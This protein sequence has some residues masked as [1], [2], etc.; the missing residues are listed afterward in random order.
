[1]PDSVPQSAWLRTTIRA[2]HLESTERVERRRRKYEQADPASPGISLPGRTPLDLPSELVAWT[3]RPDE[4]VLAVG[5][6]GEM[7]ALPDAPGGRITCLLPVRNAAD[8]LPGYLE[9]A[10]RFADRVIALDDG[11][12]DE[13]PHLLEASPLVAHVLRSPTRPGYAGWDDAANRQRLLD[14]AIEDDA[15]WVLFLDADERIDADDATALRG[16]VERAA[17][18]GHAYGFRVYRMVTDLV[19]YDRAELWVYRLFRARPGQVLPA[20]RLHLVPVPVGIERDR[21]RKTTVRIQHLS[22]LTPQRRTSRL[23]KYEQADPDRRWQR[24][25]RSLLDVG[26]SLRPWQQRPA[27]LPLLADPLG[28]GPAGE[29]DLA[30]LDPGAPLL[31][32][33]VISRNDAERIERS[34]SSVVSQECDVPFE[35]IVAAGGSD[36]T[37]ELVRRRFP[38]VTVVDV[39][40]PG[41]PGAARNAGLAV[42]RGE[43]VSFPGSH[44]E[45]P[46]GSLAARVRAH[47]LG[48]AMVTGSVL[49][50]TDTGPGWA[51]YFLDHSGSLPE[52]PSGELDAAPAHCSYTLEALLE[53]GGFPEDMRAGEDTVVNRELWTRGH[54]AYRARD[55]VLSHRNRCHTRARLVRHHFTR[56]RALGR[57]ILEGGRSRAG[58]LSYLRTYPRWR[59]GRTD[60]MVAEWGGELRTCYAA[61]R[62]LVRLGIVAACLGAAA[63]A[64][65]GRRSE[66]RRS[67]RT[68]TPAPAVADHHAGRLRAAGDAY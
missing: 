7:A 31:S 54:R 44:V 18:P 65:T 58:V 4:P 17:D 21:W 68:Q 47:E 39:P 10:V 38:S 50:G 40:E 60:S 57:I 34:V 20:Q 6:E 1:M 55:V 27:G 66:P 9:S 56:G 8:D 35:V 49:N 48:Y 11:S 33:I 24:D 23:A 62:P 45:L 28:H 32:A 63:E 25:Y 36:G 42:A 30:A 19:H 15:E 52:R 3:S 67:Q 51:S 37:A 5:P 64:L 29:L 61:V 22:S 53:V 43:F 12:S 2:R 59:L 26:S 13:T 16:F 14:A 41:L 46:Q